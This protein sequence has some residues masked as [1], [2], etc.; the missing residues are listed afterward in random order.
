MKSIVVS[1]ALLILGVAGA[2][3]QLKEVHDDREVHLKNVKQ[4]T[5]GG[6]NAEAYWSPDGK[7]II[8]QAKGADVK[9]DQMYVMNADGTNVKL[10]STGKGRCTCGYFL[11]GGKEVIFSSTHG[12]SMDTPVEPDRS[13]GYVWPI[14]PYYAIYKANADGTNI[15]LLYPK[16]VEPGKSFSYNAESTVAPDGKH[17]IFTSTKDGDLELYSMKL[18][19]SDVK[20]LTKSVGYDGGAY[21]SPDSKM[22]VWRAHHP[23]DPKDLEDYLGLLHQ[24]LVRPMHMEIM[25][26][27]ADGSNPQAVTHNGE[28]NFAPY[29]TSDGKS[30]IFS[31]NMDDPKHRQFELYTVSVDGTGL[32]RITFG[33]FFDAF[34]MFSPDGKKLIWASNRH[35]KEPHET[36]IFVADWVP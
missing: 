8:F 36:N 5:F 11:P 17:I 1:G 20:Q 31:S 29:F 19:G 28:A 12:F 33:D 22:I 23:N 9:A 3:A 35:G 18:N 21:Y 6:Q 10:V 2:S 14:Y 16:K 26:A 24:D 4:L 27:N 30:I 25:V 32:K 13:K 34:P 7:K 15:R